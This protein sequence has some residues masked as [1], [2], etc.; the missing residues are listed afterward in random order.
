MARCDL[1]VHSC[2]SGKTNHVTALEPMDS[3]STPGRLYDM[4]RRRGMDLVT[5]TDHDSID[6][7]LA[8]L[9]ERPGLSDFFISEEVSVPLREFGYK[10]HV[11]VYRMEPGDHEEIRRRRG[12][13][14]GLLD[15]LDGR[16]L[17]YT[18]NHPFYHFP[19][20]PSGRELLARLLPRFRNCEGINSC[21]P[22]EVN[23]AFM[24]GAARPAGGLRAPCW[25]A[26]SDSHSL[27]RVGRT[28]TEAPGA[29]P[30][31]FLRSL[32]RGEGTVH[33]NNGRFLGV[34]VDAMSVY[35]GY[36]RDVVWRNEIH[37]D[38]SLWK[39]ARNMVGWAFW[40]PVFTAGSLGYAWFQYRRFVRDV[41]AYRALWSPRGSPPA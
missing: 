14:E 6:G 39:K 26:G 22:P 3:Y 8:L 27:W 20:G 15:W 29:D 5:I 30:G 23:R 41:P 40:L 19:L 28:W 7:C 31:A 34:F 36:S 21:L 4:A 32:A 35:I 24:E 10:L 37:R 13:W 38:W 25:T 2:F 16:G 9:R 1:H 12:D 18:W 17:F 33:G 11:G